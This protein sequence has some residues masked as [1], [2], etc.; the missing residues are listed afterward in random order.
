MIPYN[1]KLL[2]D[3]THKLV[4]NKIFAEKTFAD[5]SLVS[6]P[7][8]TM[9]PNFVEKTFANNYKTSKFAKVSHYAVIWCTL[10]AA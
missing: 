1:G 9:P 8:D 7:K 4:E 10:T 3:K 6:P 5:C 2:R